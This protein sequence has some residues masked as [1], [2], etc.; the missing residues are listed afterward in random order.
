L[1]L[2]EMRP[3]RRQR[4]GP[5]NAEDNKSKAGGAPDESGLPCCTPIPNYSEKFLARLKTFGS[6]IGDHPHR[7]NADFLRRNLIQGLEF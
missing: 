5:V 4:F 6:A 1:F 7:S 3:G 2:F